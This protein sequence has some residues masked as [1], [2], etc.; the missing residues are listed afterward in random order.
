MMHNVRLTTSEMKIIL[1]SLSAT[2]PS[3]GGSPTWN[4]LRNLAR[5]SGLDL[6]DPSKVVALQRLVVKELGGTK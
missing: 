1:L 4:L 6:P 3:G 5:D 2:M